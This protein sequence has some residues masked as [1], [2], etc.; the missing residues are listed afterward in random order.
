M[1]R[2]FGSF[3]TLRPI[4][5]RARRIILSGYSKRWREKKI[6]NA[7]HISQVPARMAHL[8]YFARK[9][10]R[11]FHLSREDAVKSELESYWIEPHFVLLKRERGTYLVRA[12]TPVI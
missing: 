5:C 4:L 9:E 3:D 6:E 1:E 12:A 8:N 10:D 11:P 2:L 7:T